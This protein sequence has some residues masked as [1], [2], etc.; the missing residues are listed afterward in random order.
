MSTWRREDRSELILVAYAGNRASGVA[1][2]RGLAPGIG[3]I[4][5]MYVVRSSAATASPGRSWKPSRAAH[6]STA[7]SL[8]RLDT[9]ERLGEANRL[10]TEGRISRGP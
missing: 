5:L 9:H 10:H 8:I 7:S 4:K 6:G 3:E 2:L 1:A